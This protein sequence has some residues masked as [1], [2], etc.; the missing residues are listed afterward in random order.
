MR[1]L[2][3]PYGP[4]TLGDFLND[5][6]KGNHGNFKEFQLCVAFVKRSG[7]RHIQEEIKQFTEKGN[8]VRMV[9][10]I[11]H[12]GTSVEGLEDLLACS[13]NGEIWINNCADKFVTFDPKVYLFEN[14]KKAILIIGSQNLTE[15]G[16]FTNDECSAIYRLKK[17]IQEDDKTLKEIK[18]YFDIWCDPNSGNSKKLDQEFLKILKTNGNILPE[19]LI[20]NN[21][22]I[23]DPLKSKVSSKKKSLFLKSQVK[24][25]APKISLSK[26]V[27]SNKE[28]HSTGTQTEPSSSGFLMT[29][30]KTDVG[31]G[32]TTKGTS[33]RSPE[34][35]VPLSARDFDPKFWGWKDNF[36]EDPKRPGKFDRH[37]IKM[38]IGGETAIVNMM[39]WPIKHDF[40]LRSEVLRSAG[41]IDDIMRIEKI[42]DSDEFTYYVEIIPKGTTSY[43]Q[44]LALCTNKTR[45]SKKIW[46]YYI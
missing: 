6:L 41:N 15:G 13:K 16:L 29:L 34:I 38:R 35:F 37:G 24:R 45:N 26:P 4:T 11:D 7:V 14:E 46:G 42:N 21:E 12:F 10:G 19:A 44:Y 30:Q 36:I 31:T 27:N 20:P 25:S 43:D 22:I 2:L 39:T 8:R 9:V 33:R 17:G 1:I 18:D 32:Q 23:T 28:S 40:R 3:Q 5:I